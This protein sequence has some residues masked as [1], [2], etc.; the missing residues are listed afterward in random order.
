MEKRSQ[1][2]FTFI[3]TEPPEILPQMDLFL[4]MRQFHLFVFLCNSLL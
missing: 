3:Q 1:Y 2:I 4:L